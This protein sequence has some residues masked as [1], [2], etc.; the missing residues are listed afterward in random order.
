MIL[1]H[2]NKPVFPHKID[3]IAWLI[4]SMLQ[5]TTAAILA[6][7]H[8]TLSQQSISIC[9]PAEPK[10]VSFVLSLQDL[11]YSPPK[12]NQA[13]LIST[14]EKKICKK[15]IDLN[16]TTVAATS[17]CVYYW[18]YLQQES[19]SFTWKTIKVTHLPISSFSGPPDISFNFPSSIIIQ[20]TQFG[21]LH[22][23]NEYT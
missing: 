6:K 14:R 18:I 5:S 16:D 4:S 11:E 3:A 7:I 8:W 15:E 22:V 17:W 9:L 23:Q 1:G 13:H 12:T 19:T 2:E 10:D 21:W 20:C